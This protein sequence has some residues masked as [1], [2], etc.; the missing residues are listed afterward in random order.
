M[1]Q[2]LKTRD[3]SQQAILPSDRGV[4]PGSAEWGV[5]YRRLKSWF[6]L[7]HRKQEVN[8][9]QQAMDCDY[10]DG[11]QWTQ[12]EARAVLLQLAAHPAPPLRLA[13]GSDA[14]E[15]A[16]AKIEALRAE[17]LAWRELSVTTDSAF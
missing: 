7:E 14:V 12:E 15:I 16:G 4:K 9:F 5:K 8:R 6:E 1:A 11:H 2:D 17:W 13:A 10:R 3:T